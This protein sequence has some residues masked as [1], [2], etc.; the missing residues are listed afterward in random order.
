MNIIEWQEF[1]LTYYDVVGQYFNHLAIVIEVGKNMKK[2]SIW[3][4]WFTIKFDNFE[5]VIY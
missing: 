5:E 1:E 4:I 2:N 3:S